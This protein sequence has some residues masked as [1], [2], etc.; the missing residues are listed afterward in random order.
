[1]KSNSLLSDSKV[2]FII[3]A[4]AIIILVFQLSNCSYQPFSQGETLYEY[5]CANCHMP[6]GTGLKSLIPPLANSDW[7]KE[8]QEELPCLIR[9]GIKGPLT[10]NGKVYDTEMAG[11]EYLNDVQINN[12]INYINNAWGNEYGDSNVKVVRKALESCNSQ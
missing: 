10:V 8:H 2:K 6:D 9:K 1:M 5:H 11:I 4:V 12:V 3:S 7:L